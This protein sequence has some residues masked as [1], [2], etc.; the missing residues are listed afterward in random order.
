MTD[1][2]PSI[3]ILDLK[4][5]ASA[6]LT[7]IH[8]GLSKPQKMIPSKYFY[9]QY[10]SHLF[11]DICAL[12]E[13]YLTK[14][15]LWILERAVSEMTQAIGPHA[16]IIE[17]GSGSGIKTQILLDHLEQ[18]AGYV[19]IDIAK[20]RLAQTASRLKVQYPKLEILPV[21]G[22]F[23]QSL[24]VPNPKTPVE[25]KV[26]YF[27]GSTIGNFEGEEAIQFLRN[28]TSLIGR[29]GGLLI[30]IDLKKD[31]AILERAYN[32]SLG[33]TAAFNR[34]LLVRANRELGADFEVNQFEH[35][36][37]FNESAS[38]IEMHLAS[39]K[40]QVVRINGQKVFFEKGE[41]I[42]TEISHKYEVSE[43]QLMAKQAGLECKQ[44]WT[45]EKTFFAVMYLEVS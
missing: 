31:S 23:T 26:T 11:D 6:F 28:I 35:R 36:A 7:D 22:D 13:Y 24:Q 12:D 30:G 25:K 15:E 2:M 34:N 40:D 29:G 5:K 39:L 38:R 43:F 42:L 3:A 9:D 27:P 32:D 16:L 37:I 14:S 21:C 20:E 8:V 44:V 41:F 45:D 18:C 1:S 10:G 17:Y 19:P 4:P 33:V